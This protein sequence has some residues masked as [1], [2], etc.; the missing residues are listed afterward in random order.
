MKPLLHFSRVPSVP[1]SRLRLAVTV[2]VVVG[3]TAITS[4]LFVGSS[5]YGLHHDEVFRLL[6][7]WRLVNSNA[8]PLGM[9][10]F[11]ALNLGGL[12]LPLMFKVY[13]SSLACSPYFPALLFPEPL[14]ALRFL[15]QFYLVLS[16]VLLY[17]TMRK[18]SLPGATVAALLLVIS[19]L[20]YPHV[21]F[22][23]TNTFHVI[24]IC[25]A[26][27]LV[28]RSRQR[29]G[30]FTL[31]LAGVSLGFAVNLRVYFL[32]IIA[33]ALLAAL[34]VYPR[35]V[36]RFARDIRRVV[37]F[38]IGFLVGAFN[39]VA[40][41]A[42]RGVETLKPL[43]LGLFN[44]SEYNEIRPIDN[45][46]IPPLVESI[47]RKLGWLQTLAFGNAGWPALLLVT[48]LVLAIGVAIFSFARHRSHPIDGETRRL[49]AFS[50][51][52]T[53]FVFFFILITPRSGRAGHWSFLSPFLELTLAWIP[54]LLIRTESAQG[55]RK[56]KTF[57]A[58]AYLGILVASSLTLSWRAVA[59]VNATPGSGTFSTS[60]FA[61]HEDL[62]AEHKASLVG[63]LD[64]GIYSQ[65]Y[66]L[67]SGETPARE[68]ILTHFDYPRA[69][70]AL[71]SF[72]QSGYR[73]SKDIL[74][75]YHRKPLLKGAGDHA[76]RFFDELGCDL[77]LVRVYDDPSP[78]RPLSW[79]DYTSGPPSNT[80]Y[81]MRLRN[82]AEVV[83]R[84]N[85][86]GSDKK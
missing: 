46:T 50:A 7:Y 49:F 76:K 39:F 16:G 43:I 42:A 24:L 38:L 61:L 65:L 80:R 51:L 66:F 35:K 10:S 54:L 9:T 14:S 86:E 28:L 13:I 75:I 67:G 73:E 27:L 3:L 12:K 15:Y 20:R 17:F 70:K 1:E 6:P 69:R 21:R 81:L 84:L 5:H 45:M 52:T 33:G 68:L 37:P 55:G 18:A 82:L 78:V 63:V 60:V 2:S 19:P 22:G 29:F 44:R 47:D 34:F 30:L 77:E 57:A 36:L 26:V 72:I 11:F 59:E 48:A 25:V 32:W 62:M 31:F 79:Q 8:A 74:F 83:E 53:I 56:I 85:S 4:W 40:Y 64:W 41:N 71:A 58:I 23:F